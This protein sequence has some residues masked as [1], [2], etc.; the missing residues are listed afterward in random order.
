MLPI[1]AKCNHSPRPEVNS[2]GAS[3]IQLPSSAEH[4]GRPVGFGRYFGVKGNGLCANDQ[5]ISPAVNV[6]KR[7]QE[8]TKMFRRTELQTVIP[9][10][11]IARSTL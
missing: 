3:G 5:A 10:T 6:D 9:I 11:E 7:F 1:Q 2:P 8:L 4:A